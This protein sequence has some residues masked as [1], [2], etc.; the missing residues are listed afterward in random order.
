MDAIDTRQF[1][2]PILPIARQ[3]VPPWKVAANFDI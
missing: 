1:S 2:C 3:L